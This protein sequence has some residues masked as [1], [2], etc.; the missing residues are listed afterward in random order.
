M[1]GVS[2]A[3][4]ASPTAPG[5]NQRAL[6]GLHAER[7]DLRTY[8]R[9]HLVERRGF[10]ALDL[11][12][13]QPELTRDHVA[14]LSCAHRE[15]DRVER[16]EQVAAIEPAQVASLGGR[17]GVVAVLARELLEALPADRPVPEARG[18]R[19][20]AVLLHGGRGRGHRQEDVP[21]VNASAG[22]RAR[23]VLRDLLVGDDR[24]GLHC[25][26]A[27]AQDQVVLDLLLDD[28][29]HVDLCERR[30]LAER[31]AEQHIIDPEL[32]DRVGDLHLVGVALADQERRD[33][34]DGEVL[35]GRLRGQGL[36]VT[37]AVA[38][39]RRQQREEPGTTQGRSVQALVLLRVDFARLTPP[40]PCRSAPTARG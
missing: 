26:I 19:P 30:I 16:R 27:Q 31:E 20:Y 4:R 40:A 39:G 8:L 9:T 24:V 13:V 36:A 3:R 10:L 7:L 35:A 17:P 14:D 32:G 2:A 23:E 21:R 22:R 5:W 38:A 33:V 25:L 34:V 29:G 6:R 11:D 37:G 28:L 1:P 18:Q 15:R 12:D